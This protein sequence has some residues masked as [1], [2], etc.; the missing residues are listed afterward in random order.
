MELDYISLIEENLE[1]ILYVFPFIT[2]LGLPLGLSFFA[3]L[4]GSQIT[5][6][7][8]IISA[9]IIFTLTLTIADLLA[10]T[11]GKKYGKPIINFLSNRKSTKKHITKLFPIIS[12]N[13]FYS[14]ILTRTILLSLA[15][16]TN[17][18]LGYQ[19]LK[20]IKFL[21]AILISELIYSSLIIGIGYIFKDT[22]EY[23]LNILEDFSYI[24]ITLLILFF[25]IKEL[26]KHIK[27][28][29]LN[30]IN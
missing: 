1:T 11:I 15:P 23:I 8:E 30:K 28:H 18:I 29:H 10:Y 12:Q 9:I 25:L 22:W 16:I 5:T 24:I 26:H 20:L 14:L 4:H 17:Y 7:S 13:Y 6:T 2:Q 21:K 27:K 3:M 19:N